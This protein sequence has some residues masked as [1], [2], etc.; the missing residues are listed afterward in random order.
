MLQR[1]ASII[2]LASTA[3]FSPALKAQLCNGSLGDPVVNITF[4]NGADAGNT[5]YAPPNTY[6]FSPSDC[7]NDGFYT[8]IRSTSGCF[9]SSWHTVPSDHTGNGAFMLV[10]ASYTPGD[11]FKTTVTDLCPNTTYEFAAW[12]M[13][14]LAP[15]NGIKPNVTFTIEQPDGTILGQFLTGDIPEL[16]QPAWQQYG[17]FFTTP[18]NNATIILRITNNAPGGIGNDLALD[19]I[20]FRPCGARV[21]A[22]VQGNTDII[23][24]CEGDTEVFSFTGNAA[25]TYVSPVYQWQISLDSGITWTDIPGAVTTSYIRQPTGPGHYWY[26]MAVTE[27]SSSGIKA[28]RVSSNLI[29]IN[30]HPKPLVDAGPDRV[31]LTGTKAT[32][33]ASVTGET[34]V[35][36]WQPPD[37]L[38]DITSLNPDASPTTDMLYTLS[39][40][41]AFGCTN[42]DQVVVKVVNGIYVPTAFTPNGD[43]RNDLWRIPFLDPEWNAFVQV[44]N[45]YGQLVYQASGP[46]LA[47]DGT[48]KGEKQSTGV[49]VYILTLRAYQLTFKGTVTLIR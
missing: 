27:A 31:L 21:T 34:P 13:N 39:A 8:I 4:G 46:E 45:R 29:I 33:K 48:F 1:I 7:P 15:R 12:I 23:D 32:L 9:S 47:W 19:D 37:Y 49:F 40:I 5:A 30:V 3:V 42:D 25:S 26:R 36:T 43:G 6:T 16:A 28:C 22:V 35:F 41:S 17:L 18:A 10:N 44:Y 14:V 24:R 11:F 38:S 2:F 20:T